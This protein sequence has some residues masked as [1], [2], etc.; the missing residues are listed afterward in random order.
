MSGS[1]PTSSTTPPESIAPPASRL[2]TSP[3]HLPPSSLHQGALK[4]GLHPVH[5][6]PTVNPPSWPLLL[7]VLKPPAAMALMVIAPN[8]RPSSPPCPI[9]STPQSPCGC[10]FHS[11]A[12]PIPSPHLHRCHHPVKPGRCHRFD[13][14]H[15]RFPIS[16]AVS[17]LLPWW[18]AS[19]LSLPFILPRTVATPTVRRPCAARL[20]GRS[21]HFAAQTASLSP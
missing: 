2:L 10:P 1:S 4:T 21:V 12:P 20:A 3:A 17:N 5:Q 15:R 16:Q 8:R 18:W 9:K 14:F 19:S 6:F 11:P 7:N 13:L